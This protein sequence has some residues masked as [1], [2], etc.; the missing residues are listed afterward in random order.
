LPDDPRIG[1]VIAGYRIEASIGR[2]GAGVVYRAEQLRLG[3]RVAIKLIAPEL[4]EDP[5][6]RERFERESRLAASIEHPNLIPVYEADEADGLL[7]LV[8]R[9]IPG[10]DLR[11]LI[12]DEGRLDPTR[13]AELVGQV[14]A[15]LDAAHARGLVHRDVK[16]AN[17]LI[18]SVG[19]REHVY[20]TDFGLTKHLTSQAALTSTGE[21]LGTI[22]YA[23]PEQIQGGMLDARTDVYALGCVLDQAVT[24]QVPYIRDSDMAK[25]YA[26]LSEPPPSP[27]A[28]APGLPVELDE[29]IAR[30]MAKDP[31]GRYPSAGDL[32][33]AALAAVERRAPAEPERIVARGEAAPAIAP[34]P[35]PPPAATAPPPTPPAGAPRPGEDTIATPTGGSVSSLLES[36]LT[37][38]ARSG[39]VPADVPVA[40]PPS[41]ASPPRSTE[42]WATQGTAG[43]AAPFPASRPPDGE[44]PPPRSAVRGRRS[45]WSWLLPLSGTLLLLAAGWR[46]LVGC[47]IEVETGSGSTDGGDV[48]DYTVFAPPTAAP[49]DQLMVQV[50]AHLPEQAADAKA[51]ASELD[52]DARRRGYRSLEARV[53]QGSRLTFEL[54]LPGLQLDE[55]AASLVWR[56]RAEAVQFLA[57]VPHDMSKK[58]VFGTVS[59]S[60][61][62]AP[63]GHI[64]FKLEVA[65]GASSVESEPLG[66]RADRY[67]M[68]FVSYSS[69]DR[70]EVLRRVQMLTAV[71]V[72]YFQDLLSI[73]PG[74][75]WE[76]RI[77]LGIDECDLFLLFW[78]DAARDSDWVRQE[79]RY[80]LERQGS[81][82]RLPPEIR[83][84]L[85]QG[86]PVPEPWRELRHLHF[87]D[88]VLYFLEPD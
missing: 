50:F 35:A 7:Y 76:R 15:A 29:V 46:W 8:M 20:L 6:F 32:G 28:V 30:A 11:R 73:E 13:A 56:G 65:A 3:R 48:V 54:L 36:R 25:M 51:I 83:P 47:T 64:K 31:E 34:P 39:V 75:R 74:D 57:T 19:G 86:P 40:P 63:L 80:A 10:T 9:Y 79:V 41:P 37:Y 69:K 68:A 14:A 60:V 67:R 81:G 27:T 26:H 4:G 87:N 53:R 52:P 85:L 55:P 12:G 72:R 71:D 42:T 84:V 21:W 70:G 59:V 77:E 49:G 38:A 88:R 44:L 24:G 16:P 1:S 45:P 2:G 62:G 18:A 33:R 17:V 58:A 78:S 61:D 43:E 23:A 22:D 66:E 82:H 5:G